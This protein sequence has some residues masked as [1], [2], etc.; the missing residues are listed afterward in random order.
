MLGSMSAALL[1][2]L[3]ATPPAAKDTADALDR[4]TAEVARQFL[5]RP[6]EA[7]VGLAVDGSPEPLARALASLLAGRLANGKAPVVLDAKSPADAEAQARALGLRSL[8]RVTLAV[9]GARVLARGDALSTWVNFWSGATPTRAGPAAVIAAA[10]DAEPAAL[11]LLGVPQPPAPGTPVDL[12]LGVLAKLAGPPAALAA[13]DLDGD[14]R[15]EVLV[16]VNEELLVFSGDGKQLARHDLRGGA[17]SPTPSREPFGA[18]GVLGGPTRVVAWSARRARAEVL[19]WRDGALKSAALADAV[20]VDGVVV[21]L[22]PGF[23]RFSPDLVWSGKALALPAPP[24]AVSARGAVA[25]AV[26]GDGSAVVLRTAAPA[27]RFS[28]VGAGSALADLDGDGTPEVVVSTPKLTVDGDEVRVMTAAAAEAL[29]ARSG[30][31]LEAPV[32]WQ[33]TTPRGRVVV[34]AGGDL[35]GDGSDEAILGSWLADG[36]GELLF[37]RRAAP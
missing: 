4:L 8:V 32:W 16:L 14:R 28:A 25:L 18:L 37:L 24:Q 34:A 2:A 7:P 15:A 29:Q 10:V 11:A 23:N 3:L 6:F 17:L 22:D 5:A 35:D 26:F 13:A 33:G 27:S 12:R 1:L 21:K 31:A 9:D 20:P 19:A 30:S 36:T